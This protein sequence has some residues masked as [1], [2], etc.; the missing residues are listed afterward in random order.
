[1]GVYMCSNWCVWNWWRI[2][3]TFLQIWRKAARGFPA[4][5]CKGI[6]LQRVYGRSRCSQR[7]VPS[8]R[9]HFQGSDKTARFF[10][11][12]RRSKIVYI[13][14]TIGPPHDDYLDFINGFIDNIM[15]T[16]LIISRISHSSTLIHPPPQLCSIY[17]VFPIRMSEKREC[18]IEK[19]FKFVF[20]PIQMTDILCYNI[21]GLD[22]YGWWIW[23]VSMCQFL[24]IITEFFSHQKDSFLKN[25]ENLFQRPSM[26][27]MHN[28]N[29]RNNKKSI[30]V[31]VGYFKF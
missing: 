25:A 5:P 15:Q 23:N 2:Q 9:I 21:F 3:S 14:S 6:P 19:F 1:M 12:I 22:K 20:K 4:H 7:C 28:C 24:G 27:F 11:D 8:S 29:F 16:Y 31:K 26:V 10:P 17:I 13:E 18:C 30:F